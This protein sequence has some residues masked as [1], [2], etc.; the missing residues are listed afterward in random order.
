MGK[1]SDD[2]SAAPSP[3]LTAFESRLVNLLALMVIQERQQV[4]QIDLLSRAGFTSREIASLLHTTP[5]TVSVTLYQ[6]KREKKQ[7][8]ARK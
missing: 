5:N 7:K 6:Q 2:K 1:Q 3:E 8:A 4:Q